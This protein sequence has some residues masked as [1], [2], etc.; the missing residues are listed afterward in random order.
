MVVE[1]GI[2]C[3]RASRRTDVCVA[4]LDSRSWREMGTDVLVCRCRALPQFL[5]ACVMPFLDILV[6]DEGEGAGG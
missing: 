4:R 5:G 1:V 3:F 6:G 2:I